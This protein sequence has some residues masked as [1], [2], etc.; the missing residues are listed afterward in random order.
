[1]RHG[2]GAGPHL[3]EHVHLADATVNAVAHG[4]VDQAIST[5]DGDGWLGALLGE[6]VQTR[7][8]AAAQNDGR[9]AL[10]AD[11]LALRWGEWVRRALKGTM[12]HA[13]ALGQQGA[14]S[15][16]RLQWPLPAP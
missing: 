7:A 5:A 4:H 3:R 8:C 1:M 9:H 15:L 11:L 14:P 16:S 6:R 13:H 12:A 2:A 10:G